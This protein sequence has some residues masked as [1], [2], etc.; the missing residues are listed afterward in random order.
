MQTN[1]I[2]TIIMMIEQH[3]FRNANYA[4]EKLANFPR[5]IIIYIDNNSVK[6]IATASQEEGKKSIDNQHNGFV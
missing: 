5:L 2:A 6:C 1:S 3:R 4:K